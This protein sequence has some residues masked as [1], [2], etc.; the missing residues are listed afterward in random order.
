MRQETTRLLLVLLAYVWIINGLFWVGMPWLMR[1]QIA[2]LT[3]Q[4]SALSRRRL[5]RLALLRRF[6]PLRPVPLEVGAPTSCCL[7]VLSRQRLLL[8]VLLHEVLHRVIQ[9]G[10]EIVL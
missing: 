4:D 7:A 9:D 8:T 2:W 3:R 1:D 6:D 5:G 10:I